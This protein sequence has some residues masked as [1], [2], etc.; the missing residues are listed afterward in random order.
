M[1]D[2]T[3]ATSHTMRAASELRHRILSGHYPG[4]ARIYEAEVA[5]D[6]D[7]SR[8]PV[9]AA[10]S[11]LAEEGLL[12][13]GRSGGF[14]VR[15]FEYQDFADT[16]QL[17][18]VL[19]G[20]AARFAAER[21]VPAAQWSEVDR[22]LA[23]LDACVN[24]PDDALDVTRYLKLNGA[25]HD[26]LARLSGSGVIVAELERLKRLPFASPSAF[27]KQHL[28]PSQLSGGYRAAQAQ[29]RGIVAAIR[30]REGSRAEALAREHARIAIRNLD[31]IFAEG[32]DEEAGA[33]ALMGGSGAAG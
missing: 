10:L 12:E 14:V 7:V 17:R 28:P 5:S 19:E 1:K 22:L 4:G 30:A 9:R 26:A 2:D 11:L 23:D 16:I 3:R 32:A 15:R 29:H 20:T 18:G 24:A 8:T 21:G 6:L 13:R 27:V 25:F 31:R 33:L